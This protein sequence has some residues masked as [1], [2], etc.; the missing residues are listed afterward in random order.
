MGLDDKD[1]LGV[2][3][4]IL[5]K[6]HISQRLK[7]ISECDATL[8]VTLYE[9]ILGEKVPDFVPAESQEDD[10]HNMQSVIDSL[11]LDF[12]QINLSHITGENIV[13]GEEESIRNLLEIFEGLV[14]YLSEQQSEDDPQ[15]KVLNEETRARM[16]APQRWEMNREQ[17]QPCSIHDGS[18][19]LSVSTQRNKEVEQELHDMSEK[20]SRRLEKLDL[21]LKRAVDEFGEVADGDETSQQT[22][23]IPKTSECPEACSAP[24]SRSKSHSRSS[25]IKTQRTPRR[26]AHSTRRMIVKESNL[27]PVLLDEF[28]EVPLSPHTLSLMWRKQLQHTEQLNASEQQSGHMHPKL[29]KQLDEAQKKHD[30]LV[31]IIR[32]EQ[33]HSCRLREVKAKIQL[34]KTTQ[35]KL[36][37]QRQQVACAKKYYNRY[38]L[39]L[40]AKLMQEKSQEEKKLKQ[41]FEEGL[42]L[43]KAHLR[44]HRAF[45]KE[46][47]K[48][49]YRV[50]QKEIEAMESYYKD[51]FSLLADTL[52]HERQSMQIR[53]KAQEKA[54]QKVKRE[55]RTKME[56]DIEELQ[57]IILQND[58][59]SFY[60]DMEVERLRKHVQMAS[61]QYSTGSRSLVG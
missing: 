43:Q 31:Q 15:W 56:K 33:E 37:E 27:L 61:F 10:I 46:L 57:K 40:R 6:C 4:A 32:K 25:R 11:A 26:D 58:A 59:N 45:V 42:E 35:K 38:H 53:K 19:S 24:R 5:E 49:H 18:S 12:L 55:L 14:D 28:P 51:Q 54:L 50:Y 47:H 8:F 22:D 60:R 41:I 1:W 13:S 34:Q 36:R 21:M 17:I 48:E 2:A 44:E 30:L 16:E 7:R 20:L 23:S 29:L 3:N 39:Q 9:A 52:A